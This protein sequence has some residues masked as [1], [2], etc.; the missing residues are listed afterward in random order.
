VARVGVNV[1]GHARVSDLAAWT[2]RQLDGAG[3]NA[4]HLARLLGFAGLH[5]AVLDADYAAAVDLH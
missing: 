1:A 4:G 3:V 2:H 5:R